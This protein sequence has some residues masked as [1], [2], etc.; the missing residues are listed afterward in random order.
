[1]S[2][3]AFFTNSERCTVDRRL[4]LAFDRDAVSEMQHLETCNV[5]SRDVHE[6]CPGGTA[7]RITTKVAT[8][9]SSDVGD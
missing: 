6:S 8:R 9:R 5:Q 7:P 4:I 2:D 3:E 1:M